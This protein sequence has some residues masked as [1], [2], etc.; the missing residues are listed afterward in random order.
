[1]KFPLLPKRKAESIAHGVFF[2]LLGY[3]F[4]TDRWWPGILF[5]LG[6]TIAIRQ[7]LTGRQIDFLI[8]LALI[9]LLGIITLTGFAFSSLF[10]LLF[11]AIGLYLVIREFLPFVQT[12]RSDDRSDVDQSSK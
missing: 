5:A 10:P 1:M 7:I 4:Y 8:T 2:I 11:I 6:V 3:L 12:S 9:A